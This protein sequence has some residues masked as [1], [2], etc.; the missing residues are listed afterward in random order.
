MSKRLTKVLSLVL[1]LVMFLSVS[2]PAFAI[3]GGDMGR[4]FGRD[5]GE[6]E[7]RDFEPAG[8]IAEEE[9]LDYFQTTVE[10]NGSQVTVEAPMG[11]LPTLAEL[12]AETVEVEDVR[13]A[14]E[15]VLEGEANIL[16]AMDISFWLNGIEIEPEE[17]VRVKISAPELEGKSNLTLV[18]IPDAA[19]PE[20]VELIDEGDL[21]FA[22]GTNE[23]AFQADSFSIYVITDD[24][25]LQTPRYIYHF[26][27]DLEGTPYVFVN[28]AGD[29]VDYQIVKN[30]EKLDDPGEPV[31]GLEKKFLGWFLVEKNGD[32]YS[33]IGDAID[34]DQPHPKASTTITEDTDVYVAARYGQVF[35][36][37]FYD[38]TIDAAEGDRH[39]ISKRLAYLDEGATTAEVRVDNVNVPTAATKVLTGWY[40]EDYADTPTDRTIKEYPS[41][42]EV[43][44][45]CK[46]YPV[47]TDGHWLRFAGGAPGSGAGYRSA[48]FVTENTQA[49]ELANLG[50]VTREGYDF[51]GWYY[52][53]SVDDPFDGTEAATS[54][55]GATIDAEDL[56]ERAKAESITLYGHWTGKTVKYKVAR[57]FENADDEEYSYGYTGV[58]ALTEHNGTAGE[59]TNFTP[60]NVSGF[61][62]QA[63][64][65]QTIKGD[66]TTIVNVYYKR[67]TYSLRFYSAK[68]NGTEYENLRITAK[69]G[70][71]I[72]DQWPGSKPGTESYGAA[73]YVNTNQNDS[74][75]V[76]SVATM[77]L[78]GASFYRMT[79]GNRTLAIVFRTQNIGGGNSFTDFLRAPY[80]G[81]TSYVTTADDYIHFDGFSLN[82]Y[83]QANAN[84]IRQN[85]TGDS[86]AVYNANYNRSPR[87]GTSYSD[88]TYVNGAYTLYF[89]YLR[90]Q[91]DIS[92][93]LLK[94]GVDEDGRAVNAPSDLSD[95]YYEANIASTKETQIA[96]LNQQFTPGE[97]RIEV[98]NE[99]TYIFQ[100]WYDNADGMG[101]P[102]DFNQ[103]MPASDIT[104]YAKWDRVW[105]LINIDPR[106]GEILPDHAESTYT[107]LQYGQK[108]V[109]YNILRPFVQT[110]TS[111]SGDKYYY[112]SVLSED[113]PHI[114]DPEQYVDEDFRNEEGYIASNY[115]KAFYVKVS[116]F[117]SL[118]QIYKDNTDTTVVYR[119]ANDLDNWAFVGWY[120]AADDK[121]YDFDQ[122]IEGE[123]SIYAKWRRSGLFN[124]YY[125]TQNVVNDVEVNGQID[126]DL[127]GR[128][129]NFADQAV[130]KVA[131]T[132]THVTP[133]YVFLGWKLAKPAGFDA[134]HPGSSEFVGDLIKQGDDFTIDANYADGNHNIH[135]VAFYELASAN[136]DTLPV[137]TVTFNPNFPDGATGTSGEAKAYEGVP[138]NTAI[139]LSKESFTYTVI[140]NETETEKT[141]AIPTFTW[142]GYTLIGWNHDQAAATAGT[143]EFKLTDVVGIDNEDPDDNTLYAVWQRQHFYVFHSYTGELEA[144]EL[145]TDGSTV[146]L[147]KKLSDHT[148]Y[149]GYFKS[150]L[151]DP[152]FATED[153]KADAVAAEGGKIVI[154]SNT[155][156]GSASYLRNDQNKICLFWSKAQ[157][158]YEDGSK[159]DPVA[160]TVYY[161]REVPDY[162]LGFRLQYVYDW[163]YG[164][165]IDNLFLMTSLDNNVYQEAGFAVAITSPG[166]KQAKFYASYKIAID[167]P[168]SNKEAYSVTINAET[169]NHHAGGIVGVWDGVTELVKNVDAGSKF[170]VLPYWITL[171]GI[172]VDDTRDVRT[173]DIGD[174]TINEG[175]GLSEV[176]VT[177]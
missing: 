97:T 48:I 92:F 14:V 39:I 17:P 38:N 167:D 93:N 19:D 55:S 70:A 126:G 85:A 27:S 3:G 15:S 49:S 116:E 165:R 83:S 32:S 22:L 62:A 157:A 137:T 5:I 154:T 170:S 86:D 37:T 65:Q 82:A 29:S 60:E 124:V 91:Y 155:Y 131:F 119:E 121:V 75:Y 163:Y 173:F 132:P 143:V 51:A 23:I 69:F 61:T 90:N 120:N 149:G 87:I 100:G 166:D 142:T 89:Y 77:P 141:C 67:N 145:P 11:A 33:Y 47:F 150:Y 148:L 117:N 6:N 172:R 144:I 54:A 156:D 130:T 107:W 122:A 10:A 158:Y 177:P 113:D 168:N 57:W 81:Y 30:D 13:A 111:Y 105:Y 44:G 41:W 138:L 169:I 102:F 123:T 72:H 139:D 129:Y 161:L 43:K 71:D 74:T 136:P 162:F 79:G 34:F 80:S 58:T 78:N 176:E 50:T 140:E 9:E 36:V 46:L 96:A 73:W 174:K 76:Q 45:D 4:G 2:T 152:A 95:I 160:E 171:D 53:G 28:K 98:L 56:L 147:T 153:N 68:R 114:A 64:E 63:V 133:K 18:H 66:G 40:S 25:G 146:D 135:L 35:I 108:L 159:L 20:T 151:N 94:S 101:E 88:G 16:L 21:S 103:E 106:G 26:L 99:G 134:D 118:P 112:V 110:D 52:K 175:T 109:E 115:R 31:V 127:I 104:L 12:R 8:E 42:K 125:H 7:I 1:T 24:S 84:T 128:D 59:T 164:N